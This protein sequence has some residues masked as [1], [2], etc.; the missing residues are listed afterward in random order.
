MSN[1]TR[2]PEDKDDFREAK[3]LKNDMR[4]RRRIKVYGILFL[5]AAVAVGILIYAI[6]ERSKVFTVYSVSS[7][8]AHVSGSGSQVMDFDGKILTYSKDGA[9]CMDGSG[10]LLWNRTYDMQSPMCAVC[11]STA[12]FADY[13]GSVVYLQ[14]ADGDSKELSTGKPIRKIAVSENGI[15]A[16]VL[17]DVGV[18][19]IYV[20]DR[21]GNEIAHF[22]TTMEK[23][24][25][26]VDVD[27]SPSG[28]LVCVSYFFVDSGETRTSVAF[29]NFG[30]VGKNNIDNYVS[31]YN[32]SDTVMPIVE[33]FDN[34]NA[35]GFAPGRLALYSGEHK[36][37]SINDQFLSDEVMAVYNSDK[38]ICVIFKNSTG[39]ERYRIETYD[40]KGSLMSSVKFDFDFS[41]VSFGSNSYMLYGD[42]SIYIGTFEGEQRYSG[43]YDKPIYLMLSTSN[44]SKFVIVTEDTVDNVVFD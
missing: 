40:M 32:Y 6:K 8:I 2:F 1:I 15:V 34:S 14:T 28:E 44:P 18:T 16:A 29:Y 42:K 38:N 12:A 23:S 10:T 4:I 17:E 30:E 19:W 37:V 36:P 33:F 25:Y 22:R 39:E 3:K 7:S 43:E 31:G 24:G 11:H 35:F 41:G 26:P 21:N 20:Y 13:G 27:I 5:I 9:N